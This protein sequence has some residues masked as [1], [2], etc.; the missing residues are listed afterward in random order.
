MPMPLKW[1][2]ALSRWLLRDLMLRRVRAFGLHLIL[3]IAA[4]GS[5]L[6]AYSLLLGYARII[7]QGS[8][9]RLLGRN[10]DPNISWIL[11]LLVAIS[12][13]GLLFISGL[14]NFWRMSIGLKLARSYEE[15]CARRLLLAIESARLPLALTGVHPNKQLSMRSLKKALIKDTRFLCKVVQLIDRGLLNMGKLGLSLSFMLYTDYLLTLLIVLLTLPLVYLLRLASRRVVRLTRSRE[16]QLPNFMGRKRELI[17]QII[18]DRGEEPDRGWQEDYRQGYLQSFYSIYYKL[19]RQLGVNDLISACF[20]AGLAVVI[21]ITAG[22]LVIF[23]NM[24]WAIFVA[25]IIALRFFF[26]SC[27]GMSRIVKQY[28]RMYDYVRHYRQVIKALEQLVKEPLPEASAG[29]TLRT[30][31]LLEFDDDDDDDDDDDGL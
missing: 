8:Y 31:L 16:S 17:Q 15:F 3:D 25:Y 19:L 30:E 14:V 7:E 13:G 2:N 29:E 20:I 26:T 24:S 28:S 4:L 18:N 5:Q 1:N 27:Q 10:F 22:N 12:T 11:L 6:G 21:V 23:G 9:V